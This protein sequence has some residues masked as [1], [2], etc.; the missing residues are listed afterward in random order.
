MLINI[1]SRFRAVGIHVILCTQVPNK[2]V[3]SIRVKGVLPAKLVFSVPDQYASMLI[4]GNTDA[5]GLSP[6]GRAIF[7][8]AGKRMELQTPFINN[9]TVESIVEQAI[10]GKFNEIESSTHD[11]TDEEIFEWALSEK[12]GELDWR[13]VFNHYRVRGMT[14]IQAQAF[15]EGYEGQI[16]VVGSATY[17]LMPGAGNRARRLLAIDDEKTQ[18]ENKAS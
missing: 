11:V 16:I 14:Q 18:A 15:C 7:D 12:V 1:A 8:W 13:S 5:L 2:D 17:K 6:A 3:V 9:H 4:L 10:A